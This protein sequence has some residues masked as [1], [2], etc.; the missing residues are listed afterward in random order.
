MR[1]VYKYKKAR[2]T[3]I[4][5]SSERYEGETLENKVERITTQKE[6][7]KDGAMEIYTER[8]KWCRRCV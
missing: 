6:P 2:K 5:T 8:K 7:I 1:K 4:N 3:S